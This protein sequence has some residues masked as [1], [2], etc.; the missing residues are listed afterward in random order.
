MTSRTRG[1]AG[2][3]R[4][5]LLIALLAVAQMIA[6]TLFFY[7]GL[8]SP[9]SVLQY[10]EAVSGRFTTQHPPMM[11]EIWR[12][13]LP[14]GHGPLPM[15]VLIQLLY[16][17]SFAALAVYCAW[18]ANRPSAVLA[19]MGGLFPLLLN[20]S[21]TI[22]KDVM[23]SAAWGLGCGLTLLATEWLDR[24]RRF[25]LLCW[26]SGLLLLI[27]A[28][29]RHNAALAGIVLALPFSL[30]FVRGRI[31]RAVTF[32]CLAACMTAAVPLSSRLLNARDTLPITEIAAWDLTGISYFSGHD[33]RRDLPAPLDTKLKCYTPRLYDACPIA[34]LASRPETVARWIAAIEQ[35]P[36]AYLQHRTLVFS[37]LMRFGCRECHPYIVPTEYGSSHYFVRR[38]F[39]A[40]VLALGTTPLG[41]PYLWLAM[42]TGLAAVLWKRGPTP[43][44]VVLSL[45]PL[46]GVVST[47]SFYLT[48]P[49]DE[50]RYVYWLIYSVVLGG[51][52]YLLTVKVR[53]RDLCTWIVVPAICA[54]AIDAGIQ[55]VAPTDHIAPSMPTNY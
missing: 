33:Y 25:W 11:A 3:G 31:Q 37:M 40:V 32:V 15:L 53:L 38:A 48:A 52:A 21:G 41:R 26:A 8:T 16:W 51:T 22:W 34:P 35:E 18:R 13:L 39:V 2:V 44:R 54:V 46:S 6:T 28:T 47:L 12:L 29:M 43:G 24:D 27:G 7:P 45:I 30:I 17:A 55:T 4:L 49:T 14:F 19:T 10:N 1:H 36:L 23:L 9:D 42:A 50:F 20:F 5:Y